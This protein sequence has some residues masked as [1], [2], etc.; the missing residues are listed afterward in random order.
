MHNDKY[1]RKLDTLGQ[2]KN[3][4]L[5]T[6]DH[7]AA[8]KKA[9][10]AAEIPNHLEI[11][12]VGE[13]HIHIFSSSLET[14]HV[15]P[16]GILDLNRQFNLQKA[17]NQRQIA[18]C[19]KWLSCRLPP[20]LQT[21]A[22]IG[23]GLHALQQSPIE[24]E[25][26]RYCLR[27]DFLLFAQQMTLQEAHAFAADFPSRPVWAEDIVALH[28]VILAGLFKSGATKFMPHIL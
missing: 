18:L 7:L 12:H 8:L 2:G 11:I 4:E 16:I 5:G 28:C 27:E 9:I 15:I 26:D 21:F 17:P 23:R 1:M 19:I 10:W 13:N 6:E 14:L 22:C 3:V 25:Q 24:L 20:T